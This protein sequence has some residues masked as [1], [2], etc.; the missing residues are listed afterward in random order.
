M[1]IKQ[2]KIKI[3]QGHKIELQQKVI[4]NCCGT[5]VASEQQQTASASRENHTTPKDP[6]IRPADAK[7]FWSQQQKRPVSPNIYKS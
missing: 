3:D 5:S 1:N 6:F 7:I 2:R 4:S